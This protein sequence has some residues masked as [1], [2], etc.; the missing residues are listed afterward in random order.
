MI[1]EYL[2]GDIDDFIAGANSITR[3]HCGKPQFE[4]MSEFESL[5]DSSD[6]LKL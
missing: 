6:N 1:A 3:K 2:K 5:M 4:N